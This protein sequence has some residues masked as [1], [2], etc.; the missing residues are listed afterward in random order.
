M[1]CFG[2]WLKTRKSWKKLQDMFTTYTET[3]VSHVI[4]L[5]ETQSVSNTGHLCH[6]SYD[7]AEINAVHVLLHLL[8][9]FAEVPLQ[10]SIF[11]S[12]RLVPDTN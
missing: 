1:C 8:P 12:A 7:T 2:L 11:R 3:C 4:H 9:V 10:L 6:Q 5:Y